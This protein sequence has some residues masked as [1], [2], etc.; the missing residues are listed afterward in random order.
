MYFTIYVVYFMN[1][2]RS[3]ENL[4]DSGL[5]MLQRQGAVSDVLENLRIV[6]GEFPVTEKMKVADYN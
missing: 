4:Q 6:R 3:P 5:R 2:T 1:P